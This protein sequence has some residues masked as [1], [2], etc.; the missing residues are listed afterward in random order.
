MVRVVCALPRIEEGNQERKQASRE[1]AAESD[2]LLVE[3]PAR[4]GGSANVRDEENRGAR[5]HRLTGR[6]AFTWNR[7]IEDAAP[8]AQVR[9]K[10]A[11]PCSAPPVPSSKY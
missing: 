2:Q 10:P 1:T 5:E 6:R 9:A 7:G 4:V 8:P 3:R 11:E